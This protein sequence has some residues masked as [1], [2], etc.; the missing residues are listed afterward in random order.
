VNDLPTSSVTSEFLVNTY[1]SGYQ[2][3]PSVTGLKDGGWVVM[4][5]SENPSVADTG[6][7]GQRYTSGGVASGTEFRV[8]TYTPNQ[9]NYPS[10]TALTD[11]GWV[12]TWHSDGQDGSGLGVYG[13]RYTS[14]GV[15]SGSE[16]RVN[17]Y[18]INQQG[19]SSVAGL[20]NGGF[21]VTWQSEGQNGTGYDNY[22]QLYN[23]GGVKS[24]TEFLVNTY[25]TGDQGAPKLSSLTDGGFVVTWQSDA[26]DGSGNG[27]YG[28]RYTSG[29]VKSGVEFRI[30]TYTTD[31]QQDPV[32]TGLPDGGFVVTWQSAGQDGS[33]LGI[34]GQ[35]YTSGGVASGT[36]FRVNTY[37]AGWQG[38]P[39]VTGLTDGGFVVT[40]QSDGQDGSSYGVYGQR[41]TSGGV[42]SGS[43]F[44]VNPYTANWQGN[45][46]VAG[47]ANGGFVVTWQSDG[48]ISVSDIYCQRYNSDGTA[49]SVTITGTATQG[50][51]LTAANTLADLDGLGT[52]SY[53]WK[54]DG[55]NISGATSSTLTLGQAQ[56]GKAIV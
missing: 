19:Y 42:A 40:W 9:Q 23:S 5:F 14:A 49:V 45:A 10:V 24:G 20:A 15:T 50:Q 35:R 25:T 22:A 34:Y 7:Y 27:V 13:Q 53:Q 38:K 26:Q 8:N 30:N 2:M 54:A 43:E 29:G 31:W 36:E 18:T 48:P 39:T 47:L 12:V 1:T 4:W 41:Y 21:V 52:I 37:T 11:G 28:Q 3:A 55:T 16:F 17:T 51:I 6:V 33:G 44:R 32:V 46:T 56:V